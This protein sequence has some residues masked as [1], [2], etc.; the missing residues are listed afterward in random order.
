[1]DKDVWGT[2]IV[3][4]ALLEIVFSEVP[5]P[6]LPVDVIQGIQ[7]FLL[8]MNTAVSACNPFVEYEKRENTTGDITDE[9]INGLLNHTLGGSSKGGSQVAKLVIPPELIESL[10]PECKVVLRSLLSANVRK[11]LGKIRDF[12]KPILEINGES[13]PASQETTAMQRRSVCS[14]S[15]SAQWRKLYDLILKQTLTYKNRAVEIDG[16]MEEIL[17][18]RNEAMKKYDRDVNIVCTWLLSKIIKTKPVNDSLI[19]P[20]G[21]R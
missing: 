19:F 5:H 17:R 1:M 9:D 18:K 12:W 11:Q 14:T 7:N 21:F 13:V 16:E 8:A 4:S 15:E 10:N 6:K 3:L 20:F 2:R